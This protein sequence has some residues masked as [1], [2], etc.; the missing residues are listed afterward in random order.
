MYFLL[1]KILW[2]IIA[3][4]SFLVI[5][6]CLAFLLALFGRLRAASFIGGAAA[7]LLAILSFSPMSERLAFSLENRFPAY[8]ED[9]RPINGVIVLGGGLNLASSA[10]Q[11]RLVL[12]A[13]GDRLVAMAD[14]AR[15]YPEAKIV[16]TGGS[17]YLVGSSGSE[18][19]LIEQHL[20][21]LGVTP[22][23]ILFERASR[24]TYENAVMTK[25][26]VQPAPGEHWLLVTSALHM[27]R[28]MGL[29]RAAGFELEAYPV[30]WRTAPDF[31][32]MLGD[33]PASARLRLFDFAIREWIGLF[34]ARLIG[35]S[36]DFFP[37]P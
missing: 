3:P 22:N 19:D 9:G 29:F 5:C 26:L 1:S 7:V 36:R 17:G 33:D 37:A 11:G 18:A 31:G 27:P 8:R 24:N 25:A 15:R 2:L 12:G 16:F 20:T 13:A 28:A 35:H 30:D 21:T 32:G 34:A 4:S 14:L 23:R 6:L 10:A